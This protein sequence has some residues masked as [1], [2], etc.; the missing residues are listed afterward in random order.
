MCVCGGVKVDQKFIHHEHDD[1]LWVVACIL[2]YQHL[3]P[4]AARAR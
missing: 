1:S 3:L 4:K 2:G